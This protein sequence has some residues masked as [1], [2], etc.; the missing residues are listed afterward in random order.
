LRADSPDVAVIV[1]RDDRVL[2]NAL[3]VGNTVE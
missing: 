1:T 3:A 2:E